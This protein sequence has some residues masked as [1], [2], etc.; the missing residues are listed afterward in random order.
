MLWWRIHSGLY[1]AG[2]LLPQQDTRGTAAVAIE[3]FAAD[4]STMLR[5]FYL[6]KGVL[7]FFRASS[8]EPE[9]TLSSG[10]CSR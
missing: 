7:M 3:A 8:L 2:S 4:V 6:L 1:Q 5:Q 10:R 9:R